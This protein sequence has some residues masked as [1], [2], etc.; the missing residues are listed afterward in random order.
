MER[1]I[2][3]VI[4][5][6]GISLTDKTYIRDLFDKKNINDIKSLYGLS[7]PNI[8]VPLKLDEFKTLYY[9]RKIHLEM[10]KL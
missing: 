4:Q 2:Y 7:K 5:I 6:L 3:E 10:K 8:S 9:K 1:S